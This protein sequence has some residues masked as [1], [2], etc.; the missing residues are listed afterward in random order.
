[1]HDATPG[2]QMCQEEG[3]SLHHHVH[4][5]TNQ[6]VMHASCYIQTQEHDSG[7]SP[8]HNIRTPPTTLRKETERRK[9]LKA[10]QE[11]RLT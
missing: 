2:L 1:M 9:G 6:G 3:D 11:Q 10:K 5:H 7:V 8:L 4:A